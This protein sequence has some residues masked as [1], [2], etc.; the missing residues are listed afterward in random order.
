MPD[1]PSFP[2]Y[3]FSPFD[4]QFDTRLFAGNQASYARNYVERITALAGELNPPAIVPVFPDVD[5]APLPLS[6]EKPDFLPVEF[7]LPERPTGFSGSLTVDNILPAPFDG[8]APALNFG[9][10]P[11]P[12]S[13]ALPDAPPVDAN[14]AYP[15]DLV[16]NLPAPPSLLSLN[17][18]PFSGISMPTIDYTVPELTVVAPTPL[19]YV[20]EDHYSS[21]TLTLLKAELTDRIQ[22]GGTGLNP[23]VETMI[24]D[25]GREREARTMRDQLDSLEQMESLGYALP[26]GVWLDARLKIATENAYANMGLSREIM[27]KQAELE[28]QNVLAAL[29]QVGQLEEQL[30]QYTNQREQRAFEAYRYMTEASISIY[31]AKVQ[32]YS[33]Y[34]EA[35]KTKV[36]IFTAQVQAEMA[37]VE[38]YKAQ[39]SAEEAKAQINT[40]LVQQYRTQADV[41]LAN[42][43]VYKAK[44]EAIRS[45]AEIEKLKVDIFGE[46]V[47]GYTAKVNAYTAQ[48]EGFRAG[49][50]A[51]ASKQEAYRTQVT[52]YSAEVDAAAKLV[53]AKIDEFRARVSVKEVEWEGYKAL[54]QAE[55]SRAQ[56]LASNNQS[57]AESYKAEVSAVSAYNQAMTQQWEASVR[58][59]QAVAEIGVS[60]AKA[61]AEA[62]LSARSIS[63][64]AAKV[65][66]QVSAQL[67][68]AALATMN[69]SSSVSQSSQS[70][71]SNSWS[72]Q[73]GQSESVSANI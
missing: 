51:E 73:F 53:Q 49:I 66:A 69:W 47:R 56:A 1:V 39:V 59:A 24:W 17:I 55:A 64:D 67:G 48:V 12:F 19:T 72:Y 71:Q 57:I 2:F 7:S 46:Q 63:L 5:S 34:L 41:A 10:A 33:A 32:A 9:T 36:T 65:G 38:A 8:E 50:Q 18:L 3:K 42:V 68:A 20:P 29:Q 22:N 4:G 28:L 40:A 60:A 58:Q 15:A 62:Y 6:T 27:I 11:V 45:K 35:Y 70:S 43:E 37:K 52:A 54:A 23:A 21:A 61:N 31:N 13:D 16:V 30:I 44:I 26:P 25:R 14:F